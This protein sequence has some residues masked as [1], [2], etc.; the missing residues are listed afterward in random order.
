M[1]P[2]TQPSADSSAG[3]CPTL[4]NVDGAQL[5]RVWNGEPAID[6]TPGAATCG[7][8][9]AENRISCTVRGPAQL[10]VYGMQFVYHSVPAGSSAR[11]VVSLNDHGVQCVLE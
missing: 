3:A 4:A 10:A 1:A 2:V 8:P 6:A 11:Y 7:A 9:D 5:D